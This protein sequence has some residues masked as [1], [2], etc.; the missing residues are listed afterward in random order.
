MVCRDGSIVQL[1]GPGN[2]LGQLKLDMPNRY[3]VYLHDTPMKELFSRDNR[4]Q[5]HGC[6]R[7]QNPRELAALLLQ[8]PLDWVNQAIAA[9][10]TH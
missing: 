1:P 2:A 6:V 8:H 4:R 7:V 10:Y 9:G 3:N 5:S